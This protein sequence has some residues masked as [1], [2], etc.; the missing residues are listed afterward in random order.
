MFSCSGQGWR[1][2]VKFDKQWALIWH[3]KNSNVLAVSWKVKKMR[4]DQFKKTC[5]RDNRMNTDDKERNIK[6]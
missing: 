6:M 1:E 3:L 2:K 5:L 4:G